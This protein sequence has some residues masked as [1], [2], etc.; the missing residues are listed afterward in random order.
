[1]AKKHKVKIATF[2]FLKLYRKQERVS[3]YVT[4][5]QALAALPLGLV[6]GLHCCI[7]NSDLPTVYRFVAV[8]SL[9]QEFNSPWQLPMFL[10][11]EL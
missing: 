2:V 10:T 9:L 6:Y 7:Q 3:H 11:L 1:L 8:W 5:P 4:N